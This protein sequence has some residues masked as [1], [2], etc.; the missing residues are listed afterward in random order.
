MKKLK[1]W[2]ILVAVVTLLAATVPALAKAGKGA[3]ICNV[4]KDYATIQEAVN[5]SD[6]DIV[7][8]GKGEW[9]GANVD[10]LVEIK[11]VG[12]AIINDGPLHWSGNNF[13]FALY[14]GGGT[15]SRITGFEF[16]SDVEFPVFAYLTDDVTVDHN[17]MNN[18]LQGVTVWKGSGWN[19][20]HN[21]F[22]DLRTDCG[23]GIGIIFADFTGG[24]VRNNIASHNKISGILRVDPEDCGGYDGSGI[25]LYADY[26]WG[27][28]GAEEISNNRVINN[29]ISLASDTPTLVD[30]H[31][32]ELTDTRN[33]VDADPYPVIFDNAIGFND[34]RGTVMQI[35]LTPED[36]ENWN[37]ISRNLGD[38]RGHGLH[39][40]LFGPGGN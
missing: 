19:V 8:V 4:P 37:D 22:I 14:Y 28:A 34:L 29:T 31:A 32:I 38:N 40:S 13:G 20:H 24:F 17:I 6:C 3:G 2:A 11:G 35:T 7:I 26:R 9:F 36:L 33:D 15:G 1:K 39:P 16:S 23:G 5:D 21:E 25:V 18:S 12:G 10:R 27:S 30:V